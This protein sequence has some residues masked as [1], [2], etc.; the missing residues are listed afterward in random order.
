MGNR[1]EFTVLGPD[2]KWCAEKIDLAIEEI[3]RIEKLLT[4]F[5]TDSITY[6]INE[7]AGNKPIVVPDEVFNL[8]ERCQMI[9]RITQGAFDISYGS[10][11]KR[12]WNF[13]THMTS[14]PDPETAKKSVV[15]SL[16]RE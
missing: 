1:F 3:R 7:N 15:N 12:F 9:S 14:L 6:E 8:I 5:S 10:L 13:D 4:T 11:D 16:V 2:E